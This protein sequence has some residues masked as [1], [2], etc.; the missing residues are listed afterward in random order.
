MPRCALASLLFVFACRDGLRAPAELDA[1]TADAT[2][3][4]AATDAAEPDAA[5]PDAAVDAAIDATVDAAIDA[6]ID[7]PGPCSVT[8][9]ATP[10][11]ATRCGGTGGGTDT[12]L[13]C[14]AGRVAVGLR[15]NFSDGTTA[16]GG[17]SAHGVTLVC[18]RLDAVS[19]GAATDLV[20]Q[21]MDGTG[22]SGWS[23]S[24]PSELQLCQPGWVMIGVRAFTGSTAT[25]FANVSIDCAKLGPTGALTGQQTTFDLSGTGTLAVGPSASACPSGAMVGVIAHTGAGLDALTPLCASLV[26]GP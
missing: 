16:N 1:A 12:P 5:E 25:L 21:S 24:T 20:E 4:D 22:A 18:G 8:A 13:A 26:C 3:D 15:V 14:G 11:P 10:S 2:S 19:G 6:P 7:A 17:R 23:P 9:G